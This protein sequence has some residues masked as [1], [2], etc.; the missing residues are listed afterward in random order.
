MPFVRDVPASGLRA[1]SAALR[2]G[3]GIIAAAL[4]A[5]SDVN[6]A[7]KIPL[8]R[9]AEHAASAAAAVAAVP[10]N[11]NAL[12]ALDSGNALFRRKAYA[13][14]L[15][16]YRVAAQRAPEHAA[17]LFGVYMVARATNDTRLADSALA[18]IKA[19]AGPNR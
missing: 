17:P 8:G 1:W 15:V 12:V 10:I 7:P 9:R 3:S 19:R 6:P 18:G 2:P 11:A 4:V 13:A 5:C 14:A 16:Q